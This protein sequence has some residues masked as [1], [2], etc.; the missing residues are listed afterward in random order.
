MIRDELYLNAFEYYQGI[1]NDEFEEEDENAEEDLG[2][3]D[4]DFEEDEE[5]GKCNFKVTL[6]PGIAWN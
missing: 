4:S 6:H 3:Q 5:P 1:T 2:S